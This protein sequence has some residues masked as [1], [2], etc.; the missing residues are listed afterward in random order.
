MLLELDLKGRFEGA[1]VVADELVPL[2]RVAEKAE[3]D[4][5]VD[6]LQRLLHLLAGDDAPVVL[7]QDDVDRNAQLGEVENALGPDDDDDDE[8]RAE[9]EGDLLAKSKHIST[10]RLV[11]SKTYAKLD[12]SLSIL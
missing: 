6:A 12:L 10:F 5:A 2:P 1:Q 11:F 4:S 9:S 7:A 3:K 8:K